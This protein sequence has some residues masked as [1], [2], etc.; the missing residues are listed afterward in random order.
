MSELLRRFQELAD[1]QLPTG[2]SFH[3]TPEADGRISVCLVSFAGAGDWSARWQVWERE[4]LYFLTTRRKQQAETFPSIEELYEAIGKKALA[5][6]RR[7]DD[8]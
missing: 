3:V 5:T 8:D 6:S 2:D 7:M 4:G 1:R